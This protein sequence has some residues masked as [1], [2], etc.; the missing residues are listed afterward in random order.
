MTLLISSVESTIAVEIPMPPLCCTD[1]VP[2]AMLSVPLIR[3]GDVSSSVP[4]PLLV[5]MPELP[6]RVFV[7]VSVEPLVVS[8]VPWLAKT[9]GAGR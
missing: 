6:W 8:M 5:S 7:N 3:P 9:T 4:S 2:L 1:T